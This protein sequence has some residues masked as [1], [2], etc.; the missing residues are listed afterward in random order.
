MEKKKL[1]LDAD[2][3]FLETASRNAADKSLQEQPGGAAVV[4]A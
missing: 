2:T 4:T 3:C 1:Q